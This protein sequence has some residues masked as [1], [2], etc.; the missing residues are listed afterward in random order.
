MT[1]DNDDD[2]IIKIR[3]LVYRD[4][5]NEKE[6]NS[7]LHMCGQYA[8]IFHVEG[9]RSTYTNATFHEI[10]LQDHQPV[11]RKPYRL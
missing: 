1:A 6:K 11:Y 5:I 2:M 3:S 9:D 10:K 8:D 7:I 4:H